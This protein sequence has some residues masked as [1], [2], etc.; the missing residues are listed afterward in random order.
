[1]KIKTFCICGFTKN[2]PTL[3]SRKMFST[4]EK[5][6]VS[7][8]NKIISTLMTRPGQ[9]DQY[10]QSLCGSD[11]PLPL[12]CCALI[13]NVDTIIVATDPVMFTTRFQKHMVSNPKEV[14][15]KISDATQQYLKDRVGPSSLPLVRED[16]AST[17]KFPSGLRCLINITITFGSL[18]FFRLPFWPSS[19]RIVL[20][21][22]S[23]WQHLSCPTSMPTISKFS[24]RAPSSGF[25]N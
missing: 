1:M 19:L 8:Q 12:H 23:P 4:L 17:G 24:S 16:N 22:S 25:R 6:H 15:V 21:S 3:T 7:Y 20:P 18:C 10:H 13:P 2:L 5:M 14:P 9:E 11:L